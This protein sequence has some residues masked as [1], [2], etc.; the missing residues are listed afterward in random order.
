MFLQS[1]VESLWGDV[2]PNIYIFKNAF[3]DEEG[4][5]AS[6]S[7][8]VQMACNGDEDLMSEWSCPLES[9]PIFHT[10]V[11]ALNSIVASLA[12]FHATRGTL[13]IRTLIQNL[14]AA[15]RCFT[16]LMSEGNLA[17]MTPVEPDVTDWEQCSLEEW[18]L[19]CLEAHVNDPQIVLQ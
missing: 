6:L 1:I 18:C 12:E 14:I 5:V 19:I 11:E 8:I 2:P 16:V 3:K 15:N 13:T 4:V 17:I 10:D 9:D 7:L